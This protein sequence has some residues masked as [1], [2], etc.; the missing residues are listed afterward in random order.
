MQNPL[1]LSVSANIIILFP[2]SPTRSD[3]GCAFMHTNLVWTTVY[4]F[5]RSKPLMKRF[6]LLD[7]TIHKATFERPFRKCVPNTANWFPIGLR[8]SAFISVS[9]AQ[10]QIAA[11]TTLFR[12]VVFFYLQLHWPFALSVRLQLVH[13]ALIYFTGWSLLDFL[14]PFGRA[15][16]TNSMRCPGEAQCNCRLSSSLDTSW[17]EGLL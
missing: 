3:G 16:L 10:T 2:V 11:S 6:R 17:Q 9:P 8:F 13:W 14:R 1:V 4:R 12:S 5:S 15:S 7:H